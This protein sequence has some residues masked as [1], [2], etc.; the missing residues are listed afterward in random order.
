MSAPVFLRS[1]LPT[2]IGEKRL[3]PSM[4]HVTLKDFNKFSDDSKIFGGREEVRRLLFIQTTK[5]V[6][7]CLEV[8]RFLES[9]YLLLELKDIEGKDR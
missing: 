4:L 7:R 9:N 8:L 3:K 2:R 1:L 6:L 5:T